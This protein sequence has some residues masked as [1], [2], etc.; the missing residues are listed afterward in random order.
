MEGKNRFRSPGLQALHDRHVG[1]DPE[2]VASF[3]RALDD[4][5]IAMS[6]YE[7]R[8]KAGLSQ[9]ELAARVGT[10]A[11]VISRLEDADYEG[12]SMAM[13]R[14]V[15]TALGRRVEVRFPVV[16]K[17]KT[18]ARTSAVATKTSRPEEPTEA[19][20][21]STAPKPEREARRRQNPGR[22]VGGGSAAS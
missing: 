11:S 19:Q 6:I 21:R 20:A 14:R 16:K 1:D 8:T 18:M 3:E 9:R 10:T 12:H 5:S 13:L 7:L 22:K 15:A 2:R 17:S 4:A